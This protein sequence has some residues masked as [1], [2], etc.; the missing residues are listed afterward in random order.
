MPIEAAVLPDG[1]ERRAI[2]VQNGNTRQF[3]GWCV[4][5]HDL[6][7]SKLV[8]FRDKDRDFVRV[9]IAEKLVKPRKLV[10]ALRALPRDEEFRTRLVRWVE[11]TL[12]EMAG[13]D[14]FA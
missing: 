1:W 12:R 8:A 6:A 9:L 11:R 7:A 10:L 4:E 5:A 2:K 13:T 14:G 3:I